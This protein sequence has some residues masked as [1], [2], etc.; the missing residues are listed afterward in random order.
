MHKDWL[1]KKLMMIIKEEHF[2]EL[3]KGND[4]YKVEEA[5]HNH[6]K[7]RRTQVK[8]SFVK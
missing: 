8:G 3:P 2:E 4:R 6:Q 5:V 7:T 1:K